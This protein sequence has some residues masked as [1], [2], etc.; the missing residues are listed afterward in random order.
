M[1][2]KRRL[3]LNNQEKLTLGKLI[4][5]LRKA[6][7]VSQEDLAFYCGIGRKSMSNIE[8]DKHKPRI[9][10][11]LLIAEKLDMYPEDLIK[12]LRINGLLEDLLKEQR[13]RKIEE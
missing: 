9:V 4:K 1:S 11:L 10:I 3:L 6:K 12:E 7:G 5:R 8:T 13:N 2:L